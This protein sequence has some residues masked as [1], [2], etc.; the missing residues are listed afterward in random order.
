SPLP[1]LAHGF[2][3]KVPPLPPGTHRRTGHYL[4]KWLWLVTANDFAGALVRIRRDVFQRA[5]MSAVD[6]GWRRS[7]QPS[8]WRNHPDRWP[9]TGK[10]HASVEGM[11]V[12]AGGGGGGAAPGW[13]AKGRGGGGGGGGGWWWRPGRRGVARWGG[14]AG[15]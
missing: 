3:C 15:R 7:R 1:P 4:K 12:M 14:A 8:R 10:A 6:G 9:D 2:R 5:Q 13:R 11:G